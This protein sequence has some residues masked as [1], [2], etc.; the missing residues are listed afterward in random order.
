MIEVGQPFPPFSLP[1]QDG[2]VLSLDDLKGERAV[3][4]FYPKDDTSGCTTQAC[5]LQERLADIPGARVL[6]VSPDSPKSHR[7][8]ADKFGLKFT[9]LADTEK[10]LC[11]A[12]GVWVEKS[13]YGKKYM[14]VARTTFLLDANGIVTKVFEKVKPETHTADVI[15]ALSA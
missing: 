2:N 14:G 7:K 13:M 3:I 8:F 12:C 9:L 5:G 10:S 6:G 15:A 1:D 11:E 4:Y